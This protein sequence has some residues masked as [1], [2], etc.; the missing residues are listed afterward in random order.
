[1]GRDGLKKELISKLLSKT[2]LLISTISAKRS[3]TLREVVTQMWNRVQLAED[4]FNSIPIYAYIYSFNFSPLFIKLQNST[5]SQLQ[6]V[7]FFVFFYLLFS[8]ECS[9]WASA[10]L[11]FE[12]LASETCFCGRL[13]GLLEPDE[14]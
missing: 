2:N 14:G 7:Y 13:S 9:I 5:K 11:T 12:F 6:C 10:Y 8:S 3:A 4:N 1:M